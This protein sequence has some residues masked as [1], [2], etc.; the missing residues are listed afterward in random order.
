MTTLQ[1]AM[2]GGVHLWKYLVLDRPD[3]D[4]VP[5]GESPLA[6]TLVGG[7]DEREER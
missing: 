4:I 1:P 6:A 2:E 7:H 5:V 3:V